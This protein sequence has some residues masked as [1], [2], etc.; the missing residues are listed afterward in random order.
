MKIGL[1]DSGIGGLSILRSV[2]RELPEYDYVFYGDTANL[3]LGEKSEEELYDITVKGMEYL[4]DQGCLIVIIACNTASAETARKLQHE[5][6][7]KHYRGRKILGVIIPTVETL[8]YGDYT[9]ALLLATRRTVES[10]KYS[11]E[12]EKRGN[13][14]LKM[15]AVATPELVPLIEEGRIGEAA[16]AA[17]KVIDSHKEGGEV[18]VLGCTHYTEIKSRL[19]DHFQDSK[20]IISQDEVIPEKLE[21]YLNMHPEIEQQLTKNQ[22]RK[23]HLT[24]HREDYDKFM[25][26]LLGGVLVEDE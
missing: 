15:N 8:E 14:K 21:M 1:F 26:Q 3:P 17:I 7:P 16:H 11:R 5:F 22:E 25:Q 24:E 19:R 9:K 12:L 23:V 2:A 18:V 13:T 10:E 20:K 4:F 6:L